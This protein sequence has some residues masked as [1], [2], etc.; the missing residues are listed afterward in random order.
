[1]LYILK[2]KCDTLLTT[3]NYLADISPYGHVKWLQ[4]D[5]GT[6]FTSEPFQQLLVLN[7]L[8][9]YQSAPYSPHIFGTT[10]FYVQNKTKLDPRC[11]QKASLSAM[12]N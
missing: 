2:H 3:T 7:R 1:M 4:T 10:C 11:G 9:H 12:I 5:N 6:E 8:K